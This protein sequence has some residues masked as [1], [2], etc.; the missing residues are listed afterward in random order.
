MENV[1]DIK[2]RI[3]SVSE[4]AQITR[5]MELISAS[6]MQK[7]SIKYANNRAYF[8]QVRECLSSIIN[9]SEFYSKHTYLMEKKG[10]ATY[11]LIIGSDKGLAGDFNHTLLSYATE[12][13]QKVE[14]R[15]LFCIG[16]TVFNHFQAMGEN[17]ISVS[18]AQEPILEDARI[19]AN[20]I[21]QMYDAGE[22]DE[23]II[24][25]TKLITKAIQKPDYIR[26]L[27]V[28]KEDFPIVG[29]EDK[30]TK[31]DFEPNPT[32]VMKILVPQYILGIVYS[33]LIESKFNEHLERMRAMSAATEN[34]NELMEELQLSFNKARQEK[35]TTEITELSSAQLTEY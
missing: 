11:F 34:A 27:P 17:V 31:L 33:C 4:T 3:K 8:I 21:I 20:Y 22:M 6:K 29:E 18:C 16:T 19:I 28:L 32:A 5:A 35:I 30:T 15:K 26:L 9:N 12:Q 13:I 2:V 10:G 7:G 14:K 23:I 1:K 25:Y 24:I